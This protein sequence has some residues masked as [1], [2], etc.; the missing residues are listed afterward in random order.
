[1]ATP[2]VAEAAGD[3]RRALMI[4]AEALAV[5]G[6]LIDE[7]FDALDPVVAHRM[8]G[9]RQLSATDYFSVLRQWAALRARLVRTLAD[10]DV[11][12]VPATQ[13]PPRPIAAIDASLES[14]RGRQR[15]LPP[16]H[17]ARATS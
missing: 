17:R 15:P 6:R 14:L 13:I 10:V 3:Q 12:L 4:A 7:Q 1:M 8:K 16:Q 2:E 11:L 5:N 9:G